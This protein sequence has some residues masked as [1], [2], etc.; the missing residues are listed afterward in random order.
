MAFVGIAPAGALAAEQSYPP[1]PPDASPQPTP[2]P[3][4]Q[5]GASPVVLAALEQE[6][7]NVDSLQPKDRAAEPKAKAAGAVALQTTPPRPAAESTHP[8]PLRPF[9]RD[10]IDV[11]ATQGVLQPA[12][13]LVHSTAKVPPLTVLAA[14]SYIS[15]GECSCVLNAH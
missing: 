4:T 7:G 12:G 2:L 13:V 10:W 15:S 8:P 5:P 1:P 3:T 6:P 14:T 11:G 9:Q